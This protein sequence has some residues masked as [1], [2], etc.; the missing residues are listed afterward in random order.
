MV[1]ELPKFALA[2]AL[3]GIG[4]LPLVGLSNSWSLTLLCISYLGFAGTLAGI[5]VQ[6]A[7]QIDLDD[8]F[9]GRVMSLWTMVSIGATATGAI[10]LGGL[11]DHIGMLF[12]SV[13]RRS[14]LSHFQWAR[15]NALSVVACP[16]EGNFLWHCYHRLHLRTS[17][18]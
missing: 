11:A 7:I 6:T 10:I 2:S 5:S 14:K 1:R 3:L 16:G 17:R 8:D 15:T 13:R 4:L 9:R 18:W 12:H